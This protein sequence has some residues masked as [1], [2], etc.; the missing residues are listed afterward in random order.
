MAARLGGQI[1]VAVADLGT[2]EQEAL[3]G[4][5]RANLASIRSDLAE[6]R[7]QLGLSPERVRASFEAAL[8]SALSSGQLRIAGQ[9]RLRLGV[10][11]GDPAT[12]AAAC[13]E[14]VVAD[15][16]LAAHALTE[17]LDRMPPGS[18]RRSPD[19]GLGGGPG[20]RRAGA[21]LGDA[22]AA[23]VA[24]VAATWPGA[25]PSGDGWLLD[26]VEQLEVVAAGVDRWREPAPVS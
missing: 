9:A 11:D 4:R 2:A 22:E 13:L 5:A 17:L 18:P 23:A 24:A 10:I 8:V 16:R 20:R 19:A 26:L 6:A 15:R 3:Q 21:P 12:L 1:D 14:L 25:P 7:L